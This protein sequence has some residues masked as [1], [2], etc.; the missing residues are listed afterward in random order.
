MAFNASRLRK[1][2]DLGF[3]DPKALWLYETSAV[4]EVG[5]DTYV[6]DYFTGVSVPVRNF[7][8]GA[9]DFGMRVGDVVLVSSPGIGSVNFSTVTR[10]NANGDATIG[11]EGIA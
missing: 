3:S 10:V 7:T 4:G 6:E 9:K 11:A 5:D 8:P 1:I 2:L